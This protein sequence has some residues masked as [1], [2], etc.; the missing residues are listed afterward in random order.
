VEAAL[1]NALTWL[2]GP[3]R[4]NPEGAWRRLLGG[5]V[6]VGRGTV[7][8]GCV[9]VARE[10]AG[11]GLAVGEGSNLECR[12]VFETRGVRVSIG[13][14][15]H[16]GGGTLLD[17]ACGIEVGDDVLIAFDVLVMDHD[18]HSLVFTQR[19]H[20][21]SAWMAGR[22][23]WTH[24]PRQSVR[25]ESKAWV[26]TR[27]IILKGVTVGE[28]GVVAAGSVVT[29]DVPPWTIVAGNPARVI[30]ELTAEERAG[31]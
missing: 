11:C 24:V 7:A 3:R 27:A 6:R 19:R 18:S 12:I 23:D 29:R 31:A 4:G 9:V 15:T 14:R 1:R 2:R 8:H 20:D 21:V 25:I 16:V 30:R 13:S 10:P 17:A 5:D 26:G 22:K 28:G